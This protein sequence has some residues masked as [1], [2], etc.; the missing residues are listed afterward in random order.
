[1]IAESRIDED[2][3]SDKLDD[4]V[5]VTVENLDD[6]NLRDGLSASD[7]KSIYGMG[8][9]ISDDFD[10]TNKTINRRSTE[11]FKRASV[12]SAKFSQMSR[13]ALQA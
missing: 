5:A 13:G 11:V 3:E 10:Y 9:V 7:K 2:N 12:N 8:S 6:V 1:M 4:A